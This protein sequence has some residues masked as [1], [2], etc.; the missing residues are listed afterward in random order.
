MLKMSSSFI[1]HKGAQKT[2]P[3]T[4]GKLCHVF[5]SL[6]IIQNT[7]YIKTANFSS[8]T[9]IPTSPIIYFDR[10]FQASCL[11][12]PRL[13][14]RTQECIFSCSMAPNTMQSFRTSGFFLEVMS[15]NVYEMSVHIECAKYLYQT[16][17]LHEMQ[18]LTW[19]LTFH[20]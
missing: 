19:S 4:K 9:I 13:V 16:Q 5:L 18:L 2:N 7:P 3:I 20:M 12:S 1:A 8:S 15:D 10:K 6:L 11:F 17:G 14:F